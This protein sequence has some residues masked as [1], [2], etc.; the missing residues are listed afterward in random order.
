MRQMQ[1]ES[2]CMV[3]IMAPTIFSEVLP[4]NTTLT[5]RRLGPRD[6]DVVVAFLQ[7]LDELAVRWFNPHP[8]TEQHTRDVLSH[9]A[10]GCVDAF[11]AFPADRPDYLAGYG[12]LWSMETDAPWLGLCVDSA[13]RDHGLGR[14]L[15]RRLLDEAIGRGK[16]VVKLSVVRDNARARHL[17]ESMGFRYTHEQGDDLFMERPLPTDGPERAEAIRRRLEGRHV[18]VVPYSHPDWAWVH[19]RSWHERRYALVFAEVLDILD[20]NPDYRWYMDNF[21]CQF[22]AVEA[23]RPDLIPRIA[24]A[25]REGRMA[26]CGAWSNVRPNMVGNETMVRNMQWGRR[27]AREL[28]GDIDLSV[29]AD[30]VDV[31]V[32]HGQMPQLVRLGGYRYLKMWRPFGAAALQGVPTEFHWQ[33]LDGTRVLT[34]R[35]L[36]GG[37]W[38]A[39]SVP[40]SLRMPAEADTDR[41]LMDLWDAEAEQRMR[42]SESSIV[43]LAQ[44][45]DDSR[46]LR[47]I[48]DAPIDITGLI[49]VWNARGLAPARYATPVEVFAHL[50]READRLPVWTGSFDRCDVCYNAAWNGEQGL[51]VSRVQNDAKLVTAEAFAVLAQQAAGRAFPAQ[52]LEALWKDHLLTCAHA[53]QWLYRHDFDA[54][55]RIADRVA[56]GADSLRDA[57]LDALMRTAALPDDTVTVVFNP[58][59]WERT[60]LIPVWLS[61]Y[62]GDAPFTAADA[63]GRPLPTQLVHASTGQGG[64][65]EVQACVQVTLPPLGMTA[66]REGPA[67]QPELPSKQVADRL[68]AEIVSGRLTLHTN[69]LAITALM[70]DD[71][72]PWTTTG[73]ML[74]LRMHAVDCAGGPLHVGPEQGACEILWRRA[75]LCENG[76]LRTVIRREGILGDVPITQTLTIAAH[77]PVIEAEVCFDW[78]GFGGFL[79]ASIPITD[80]AALSA[81]I[82]FGIEPRDTAQEPYGKDAWVSQH[83][84][85]R[86]RE[87]LFYARSWVCATA[88]D[89]TALGVISINT[90]RYWLRA[91]GKSRLELLLINSVDS[92][93]EWEHLVAPSTLRGVGPHRMRYAVCLLDGDMMATLPRVAEA[94]RQPVIQRP[95]LRSPIASDVPFPLDQPVLT[96]TPSTVAWDALTCTDGTIHLRIHEHA[97]RQTEAEITLPWPVKQAAAVDFDGQPDARFAP[98][99]DG[100]TVR[101]TLAPWQIATLAL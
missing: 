87:G 25:L 23:L 86:Y 83:T 51:A 15:M 35:G 53:T 66:V 100:R 94:L 77:C 91:P 32:G 65:S 95:V 63:Q 56:C 42:H 76:P 92:L 62:Q 6:T 64:Y 54:I 52:P 68:P 71:T 59:P 9:R 97:G 34:A 16:P 50:E 19:T 101:L 84:M 79:T 3:Y 39:E 70:L 29:H 26:F 44:G 43:W 40:E 72:M 2:G 73:D 61:R 81:D 98:V 90:D 55:R 99:C 8:F 5:L 49:Q 74:A 20:A 57:S 21:A 27:R 28:F 85:E 13:Y 4:L 37:F 60:E 14:R 45:C 17:Y 36:Y 93:E 75:R 31:A 30:A 33:G 67:A 18:F 69:G 24:R 22:H 12:W 58:L 38:A 88:D 78:K 7:R 96:L 1:E 41:M 89:H 10:N 11:G 47:T 80:Q 46:P 82:P 48:D